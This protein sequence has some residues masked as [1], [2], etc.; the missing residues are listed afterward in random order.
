M[1]SGALPR[2][3]LRVEVIRDPAALLPL[4]S[5]WDTLIDEQHPGAVFRSLE[6][7]LAWWGQFAAGKRLRAY[8]ARDEAG[9]LAVLPAYHV[10]TVFG[11][12][13]LHLVGDLDVGSDYLG[14]LARPGAERQ[15]ALA[16]S[17]RVIANESDVLLRNVLAEDALVVALKEVA[18][19]AGSW[20][21]CRASMVCPYLVLPAGASFD[22]WLSER[23][24]GMGAQIRR[25]RR[26]L[27]KR[28][29]FRLEVLTGDQDIAS[30]LP[31]AWNLHHARWTALEGADAIHSP[32]IE[33]FQ[34]DSLPAL[35]RRGWA[36]MYVLH[37]D[38]APRAALNGFG[39]GGRFAYYQSGSDPAWRQRSV[40]S[41]VLAAAIE[42][43]LVHRGEREFDFLRGDEAYKDL[44]ASGRRQ[45]VDL[46]LASGPRARLLAG[47]IE[48][49]AAARD[50]AKSVLPRPVVERV[51]RVRER[52][53]LEV[54]RHR[55]A[56]SRPR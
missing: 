51:R 11:H 34:Q 28:A 8:I 49:Q 25:R 48:R 44:F 10:H 52:L 42:D 31:T 7:L 45:L 50:V 22:R 16:I 47:A 24:H 1:R 20:F 56:T 14:L 32:A 4:A 9:L 29:G 39:R 17:E 36:R 33:R 46:R 15:A 55:A 12:P 23:P 54:R 30:A 3:G 5:D 6:W 35:A 53:M 27:E 43:T 13:R 37:V 19:G 26:W 21:S 18:L 41:V 2:G 40:G 38:G